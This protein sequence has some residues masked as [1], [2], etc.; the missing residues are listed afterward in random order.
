LLQK[1]SNLTASTPL[2][3]HLSQKSYLI[4]FVTT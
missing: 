4:G 3:H 1:Q 2:V